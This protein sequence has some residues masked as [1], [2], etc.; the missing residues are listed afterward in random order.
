MNEPFKS[1]EEAM[2]YLFH[3][4]DYERM[5]KPRDAA[6][7]VF[8]LARM[9][10]LLAFLDNPHERLRV[11]HI[12]GTKGKGSTATMTASILQRAGA[13]VGLYTSPH[14]ECIRERIM[15]NGAWIAEERVTAH[16]NR[17]YPYLQDSLKT[18]EKY[19]PTFFEIFTAMAF[20][21]FL[22]EGVDFAVLEVG[23]GGR[24]DATNVASPVVCGITRIGYDHTDK[25]GDTLT[26]IASEKA[27][28]LKPGVPAV[29]APQ[30]PEALA[31]IR[32]R[33]RH[34]DAPL[35]LVGQEIALADGGK[36]FHVSTPNRRY[37]ELA[38]PLAGEHQRVNAATAIGLAEEA[39]EA[40]PWRLSPDVA[41]QGLAA[42]RIRARI[43]TIAQRPTVVIDGAHNVDSART[44]MATLASDFAF[45]RLIFVM[46]MAAD[47]DMDSFLRL[48]LARA[49]L[50]VFT[51]SQNPRAASPDDLVRR[52]RAV[53]QV[54]A[55]SCDKPGDALALARARARPDDL[56]CV[57]GSF[58]IVGEV[59][60]ALRGHPLP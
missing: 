23:L 53:S 12:A 51:R 50:V 57:T 17:F 48:V 60:E 30:E 52:A 26:L 28:I 6:T 25:L 41:R 22:A 55:L 5:A 14:V 43:E 39:A 58:Y 10:Q 8:G 38:V 2:Q 37:P 9:N 32:Q 11:I 42:T 24:L 29:I 45:D 7:S 33:A 19:T 3:F 46:G 21:D 20:A 59:L 27:G 15:V 36:T 16:L 49:S 13:R 1:Y 56:I 4:T 18:S 34:L 54:E 40:S 35:R 44:L 47:K 31:A